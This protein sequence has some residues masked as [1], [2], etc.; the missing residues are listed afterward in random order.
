MQLRI[1]RTEYLRK[2][3]NH[4]TETNKGILSQVLQILMQM[5]KRYSLVLA[6]VVSHTHS[7]KQ[8]AQRRV[9]EFRVHAAF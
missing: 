4:L 2:G 9:E 7:R 8:N 1:Q 5:E 6:Q 3:F